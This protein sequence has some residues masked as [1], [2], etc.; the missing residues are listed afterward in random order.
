MV[1]DSDTCQPYYFYAL[2]LLLLYTVVFCSDVYNRKELF[3][4]FVPERIQ[5]KKHKITTIVE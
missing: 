3:E 2:L 1:V 5:N 4:V